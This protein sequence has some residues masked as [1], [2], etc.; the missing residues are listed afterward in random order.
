MNLFETMK[1][2][3]DIASQ[4]LLH[5]EKSVNHIKEKK[6]KIKQVL[7]FYTAKPNQESFKNCVAV[8]SAFAPIHK[9]AYSHNIYAIV[10][11]AIGIGMNVVDEDY[12]LLQE[13]K[14]DLVEEN[15]EIDHILSAFGLGYEVMMANSLLDNYDCILMD[16]S[17]ITFMSSIKKIFGFIKNYGETQTGK[18][19]Q[20]KFPIIVENLHNLL[21][22]K[23]AIF[24]PKK[25]RRNEFLESLANT[26]I[27]DEAWKSLGDRFVLQHILD[28]KEY[29]ELPIEHYTYY[30]DSIEQADRDKL[31]EL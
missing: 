2:V 23:K 7:S 1:C 13:D 22:S 20:E 19:I 31:E 28:T 3:H 24:V 12:D 14:C 6:D 29:I 18:K 9:D 16:G 27:G 5:Y 11:Q 26:D 4:Q 25:S 10:V 15:S 8:D 30:V 21:S 17:V